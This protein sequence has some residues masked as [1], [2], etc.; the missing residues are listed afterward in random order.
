MNNL[1]RG[2]TEEIVSVVNDTEQVVS[3]VNNTVKQFTERLSDV[4]D[5]PL[6]KNIVFEYNKTTF[7]INTLSEK[8]N[9]SMQIA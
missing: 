5:P 3:V 8:K 4:A 6:S 1:I 7:N 9:G 2:C